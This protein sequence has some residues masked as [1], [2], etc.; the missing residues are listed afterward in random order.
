MPYEVR[1][2]PVKSGDNWAVIL[3]ETR[4]IIGRT[5]S[6][7][8]AEAMIRAIYLNKENKNAN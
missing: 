8:N 5:A 7:A 4:K 1:Y 6:K 3:K 2:K